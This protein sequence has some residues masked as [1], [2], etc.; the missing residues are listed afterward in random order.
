MKLNEE[1]L[2]KYAPFIV[3][4]IGAG[5][6]SLLFKKTGNTTVDTGTSSVPQNNSA[7]TDQLATNVNNAMT[8]QSDYY[9]QVIGGLQKQL[10][11]DNTS[12]ASLTSNLAENQATITSI[13]SSMDTL[14]SV[15]SQTQIPDINTKVQINTIP[16]PVISDALW[17]SNSSNHDD[18]N[19]T[20]TATDSKGNTIQNGYVKDTH[21]VAEV[22]NGVFTGKYV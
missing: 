2:K 9:N 1:Q 21:G 10:E 12:I 8:K 14:K 13:K 15:S 4:G 11:T 5:V 19:A 20:W 17:H 6:I 7:V 16:V 3:V 18:P 22:K